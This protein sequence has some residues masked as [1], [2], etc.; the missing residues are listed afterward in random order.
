MRAARPFTQITPSRDLRAYTQAED[1]RHRALKL[2]GQWASNL[3]NFGVP[4]PS[5]VPL[6][7][8][9]DVLVLGFIS[10]RSDRGRDQWIMTEMWCI[11]KSIHSIIHPS[12]RSR[13][14]TQR[15]GRVACS[16]INLS[17][18][19][20]P[21]RPRA[22]REPPHVSRC[23]ARVRH[24]DGHGTCPVHAGMAPRPPGVCGGEASG[25]NDLSP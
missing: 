15:S 11:W 7:E 9:G 5:S 18:S 2:L 8:I 6:P 24:R 20:S 22:W 21:R 16:V 1:L 23:W 12:A 17:L 10:M 13:R 4:V 25:A 19:A 14:R 3:M